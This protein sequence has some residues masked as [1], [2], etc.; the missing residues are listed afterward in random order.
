MNLLSI[1]SHVAY[2]HVG[3]SAAVFPLQRIGV[4][5]WPVH[6][7]QFSNHPGYGAWQGQVLEASHI[8]DVVAG[9]DD[10]GVL[11][12]CDGVLSGYMG[13]V[14]IGQAIL[15]AATRVKAANPAA[16]YCCDPIIGDVEPGVFVCEGLPEFIRD[17]AVPAADVITPN[18]FELDHLTGRND[19]SFRSALRAIDSLHERGPRIIMVTSLDTDDTPTEAVDVVASDGKQRFRVRT[20]RVQFTVN[21]AGDAIAGLFLAHLLQSG[22][23]ADAL[24]LA[25]SS[26]YGVICRTAEAG[27]RE[28]LLI[29]SQDEFVRPRR[30]FKPEKL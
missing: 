3:N 1:Q 12:E 20:P 2:G 6:T 14:E 16:R 24:S 15:D 26:V 7:V 29:Q 30:V 17:E 25:T 21:G 28:L 8:S 5:V 19:S 4:D 23:L 10:R 18:R 27:S 9:L 13:S 22:S 11:G